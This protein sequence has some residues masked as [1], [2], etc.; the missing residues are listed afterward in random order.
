LT[1]LPF[2]LAARMEKLGGS[3]IRERMKRL[4][5][6]DIVHLGG[7]LPDPMLFP[8]GRFAD[9]A[10]AILSDPA[11]ARMALSYAPSEGHGPLREWIAAR[12]TA[13][14]APCRMANILVTTG[15]QQGL[16]LVAKLVLSAG[17]TVM[18]ELPSFIGA[19]RTFDVQQVRY[20]GIPE[21]DRLPAPAPRLAYAG[22]D[23]R[24]PTGTC[25][26]LA[27]R[28]HLLDLADAGAMPVLED[29]CYEDLRYEGTHLASLL[30]LDIQRRGGIEQSRVIHAGT[31]S[32]LLA[33]ALRVGWIAAAEPVIARLTLLKQAADLASGT[34]DQMIALDLAQDLDTLTEPLRTAYR[35]RRDA[36]LAALAEHMP[37]GVT[38]SRPEGGLYIWLTFPETIDGGAFAGRALA[39]QGVATIS[40]GAFYPVD[41]ERNTLR[42]SFS[43]TSIDDARE[44][45]RRLGQLAHDMVG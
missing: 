42:L 35:D 1:R 19:L 15:S 29:G 10:A 44:G 40:G 31:F 3:E 41:A 30:A 12:M 21:G 25:L 24:N 13:R 18:L 17:D 26:S 4:G 6:R 9:A 45:I 7:G 23:F 16:D 34:L 2:A 28:E 33:P 38:W 32:K 43:L 36:M 22:P 8:I 11:K 5:E 27:G 20:A 37:E 39:E 14:G